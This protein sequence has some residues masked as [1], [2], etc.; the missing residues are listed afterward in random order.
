MRSRLAVASCLAFLA[1]VVV[2]GA[3]GVGQGWGGPR[4]A[5]PRFPTADSFDGPFNFCRG[6]YDNDR[7]EPGGMG[8]WTD[9]PDADINFSIRLSELTKTHV[10]KQSSGEPNHLVVR[11]T[12]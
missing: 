12:D 11:L 10:S 8:W 4:T 1:A 9:Y 5:P 2:A 3:Q 6:M 7:R